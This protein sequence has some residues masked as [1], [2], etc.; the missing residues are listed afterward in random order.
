MEINL[1]ALSGAA[2]TNGLNPCGIG[3]TVTFLGYLLAFHGA[4]KDRK[5]LLTTG[6]AYLLA[7]FLSYLL[8]GLFFY[9]VAYELQR[10]WFAGV[11]KSLMGGLMMMAGLLQ[12]KDGIWP[13]SPIH[14]RMP[15]TAGLKLT[16]LMSNASMFGAVVVGLATTAF[17]TPCMMPLYVGTA[18]VLAKSGL[19]MMAILGYFLYYNILFISPL[20][21]VLLLMY[22]GKG[23]V[24]MKEWEHLWGGK[25]RVGLGVVL[26]LVGYFVLN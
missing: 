3:L 8:V 9:S 16:K 11:F 26:M 23:A 14:L 4:D 20:I 25:L 7:V 13:D 19:P 12:I 21:V 10:W 6:G 17:S 1:L 2:L 18:T 22:W 24:A 15:A 5:K